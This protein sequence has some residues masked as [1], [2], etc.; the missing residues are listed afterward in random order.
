[1]RK[2]TT[3][4]RRPLINAAKSW[5]WLSLVFVVLVLHLDSGCSATQDTL[6]QPTPDG[7]DALA[8]AAGPS[9]GLNK[10]D[11]FLQYLGHASGGRESGY[12]VER[13]QRVTQAMARKAIVD[14]HDIGV[15]YLRVSVT[16]YYPIEFDQPWRS[17]LSLWRDNPTEY[18][19]LFDQMMNDLYSNEMRIVPVFMWNWIQFPA[20]TGENAYQMITD[21]NSDSYQ[22]L[23][24]YITEFVERYKDHPALYFYE[25]TNEFN[26]YADLDMVGRCSDGKSP[27]PPSCEPIGNFT[28][29][30]MIAFTS[31]LADHVRSLDPDHLVSS[32]FTMPRPAAQHL[33]RTPEFSADGPDWSRDSLAEFKE[34]LSDIHSGMDIVSVHFYNKVYYGEERSNIRL[35]IAGHT[36]AD[37]LEIVK[38]TT[39][40]LGKRLFVG[41]FGDQSPYIKSDKR[42]LFTHNV[43]DK[44]VELEIPYS[45]AW[46]WEY[47]PRNPYTPDPFFSL[48]PGRTDLIISK[49]KEA[50]AELGNRIPSPQSPDTTA[51]Q[52]IVT[53]PLGGWLSC[54]QLVYAVASD[55]SG[56]VQKVKFLVDGDLETAV[57]APPYRFD[58][59]TARLGFGKQ[60]IR[61]E[62]YDRSGNV[63]QYT[64]TASPSLCLRERLSRLLDAMTS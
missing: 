22:L 34:N 50:N 49:I 52:V 55:D 25:L 45:A 16:G 38:Q 54:N 19:A 18:W 11:L 32:G 42:A 36:N 4:T 31:R 23:K 14:A 53:W 56:D 47:Y 57:S 17:D 3:N 10:F 12:Q 51:P 39:D 2:V 1:V 5:R 9:V 40:G 29:D 8:Q 20:M 28:T 27:P 48:E 44:I 26:K 33:R 63:G 41:E 58:L 60:Q 24:E 35:D 21:P 30:Q 59:D 64:V 61:A 13:Y 37:L 62:A 15:T 43:L 7:T 6:P 46:I